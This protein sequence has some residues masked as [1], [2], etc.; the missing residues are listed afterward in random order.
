MAYTHDQEALSILWE[1]IH[2]PL[3]REIF[4]IGDVEIIRNPIDRDYHQIGDEYRR[5]FP[6]D[7]EGSNIRFTKDRR[8]NRWIWK[9]S[10]GM[11]SQIEP[12][13]EKKEGVRV[14]QNVYNIED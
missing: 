3:P 10:D 13:I 12:S 7:R 14:N 1:N 2:T 8:G 6:N 9:A 4:Y 5:E 11:H